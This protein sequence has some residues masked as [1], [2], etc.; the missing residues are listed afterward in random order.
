LISGHLE[1]SWSAFRQPASGIPMWP[2]AIAGRS[3]LTRGAVTARRKLLR[4][5]PGRE[6]GE[7]I[8]PVEI[9]TSLL[10]FRF[11]VFNQREIGQGQPASLA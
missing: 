6:A 9:G 4:R 7:S 3:G 10:I 1:A 8:H 11:G 5:L 2:V